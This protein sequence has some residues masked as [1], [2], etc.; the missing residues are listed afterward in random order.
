M[1]TKSNS[2]SKILLFADVF[3]FVALQ[4]FDSFSKILF[5]NAFDLLD[6]LPYSHEESDFPSSSVS[7]SEPVWFSEAS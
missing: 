1:L 4:D 2:V 5:I 6:V 7:A 3:D